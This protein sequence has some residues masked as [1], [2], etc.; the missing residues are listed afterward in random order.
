MCIHRHILISQKHDQTIIWQ[1]WGPPS[2]HSR[3][4]E[5]PR[6]ILCVQK[7]N[8]FVISDEFWVI[9][10]YN[11]QK[12]TEMWL[13]EIGIVLWLRKKKNTIPSE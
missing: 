1:L 6:L 7:L 11:E 8:L 3:L 9:L 4:I 5:E 12:V 2:G 10:V 13:L